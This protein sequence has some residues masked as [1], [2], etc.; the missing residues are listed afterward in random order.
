MTQEKDEAVGSFI[1]L[2][3]MIIMVICVIVS[4]ILSYLGLRSTFEFMTLPTTAVICLLLLAAD[5]AINHNVRY[6]RGLAGPLF[7]LSIGLFMSTLS[8][9]TFLYTNFMTRDVARETYLVAWAKF[10][11]N[12]EN[13]KTALRRDPQYIEGLEL[14]QQQS[15]RDAQI[16]RELANLER[17]ALDALNPGIGDLARVHR[18]AIERLL[19][20]S[21][22]P[23]AIPDSRNRAAIQAWLTQF[24]QL[25]EDVRSKAPQTSLPFTNIINDIDGSLDR[26]EQ[27]VRELQGAG[28]PSPAEQVDAIESMQTETRA[29][30]SIVN[31]AL[32]PISRKVELVAIEPGDARLGEIVYTLYNGFIQRPNP[33]ATIVALLF[34]LFVDL[35]PLLYALAL[36]RNVKGRAPRASDDWAL[37]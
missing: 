6:R 30:A 15:E 13:A 18:V 2:M 27:Q 12:M 3:Y 8:N 1:N 35:L 28:Y 10:Q 34:S 36:L 14:A 23:L 33:T 19:N 20:V 37:R 17:Q 32:S 16:D 22:T 24:K 4:T 7:V 21:L 31:A 29:V 25:V 11:E 26:F 9:F 5:I